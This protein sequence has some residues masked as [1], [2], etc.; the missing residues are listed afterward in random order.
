[1][2]LLISD[3]NIL[4]D[5]EE[6]Q[7]IQLMFQLPYKFSIP[8][9]L[10]EEEMAEEHGYL[11][12]L[13]LKCEDMSGEVML[14]AEVLIQKYTNPS[15]HDCFALALAKDKGCPLL[16]GDK[17]L[18]KA[19]ETEAVMVNGTLWVVEQMIHQLLITVDQAREAYQRMKDSA[20]RLPWA[21]AESRLKEIEKEM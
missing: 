1:V 16:T 11:P 20:R 19:A 7:L 2:Q 10:F 9:I 6:G 17:A 15:R 18:R 14:S 12:G 8:D 3:A 4:I 5:L 21:L 13:G